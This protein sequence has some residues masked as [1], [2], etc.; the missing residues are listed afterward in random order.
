MA[1]LPIYRSSISLLTSAMSNSSAQGQF[2]FDAI[3]N[4]YTSQ[5]E[6]YIHAVGDTMTPNIYKGYNTTILAYGQTG[7]DKTYTIA[8]PSEG[9]DHR[10]IIP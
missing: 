8:G 1:E 3:L 4:E 6:V 9:S 2:D 7:S 10:G 5:E